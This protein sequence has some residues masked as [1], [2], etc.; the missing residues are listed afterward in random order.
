M[1][2]RGGQR[3][4]LSRSPAVAA[5]AKAKERARLFSAGGYCAAAVTEAGFQQRLF[6]IQFVLRQEELVK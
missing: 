3:Q 4:L 5:K 1:P 2:W 6:T